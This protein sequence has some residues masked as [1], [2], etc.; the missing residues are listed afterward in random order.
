[1]QSEAESEPT[2]LVLPA[3][4]ATHSDVMEEVSVPELLAESEEE[5][6]PELVD[7]M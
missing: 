1:M 6:A 3:P 5:A 2:A 4:H 7:P